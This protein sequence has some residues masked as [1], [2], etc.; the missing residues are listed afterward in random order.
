MQTLVI[1]FLNLIIAII[2]RYPK[3][4][5]LILTLNQKQLTN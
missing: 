5:S 4:N 1:F 3:K 2:F